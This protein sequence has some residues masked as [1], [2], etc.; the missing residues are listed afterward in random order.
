[1]PFAKSQCK[2]AFAVY[3]MLRKP[4]CYKKVG[5]KSQGRCNKKS[6]QEAG[7]EVGAKG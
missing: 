5:A 2:K 3:T 6:L 7:R 4:T 1:M